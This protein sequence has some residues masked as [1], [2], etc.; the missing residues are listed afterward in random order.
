MWGGHS[1]CARGCQCMCSI[2]E[3]YLHCSITRDEGGQRCDAEV[4]EKDPV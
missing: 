4:M 3:R 1:S 2:I